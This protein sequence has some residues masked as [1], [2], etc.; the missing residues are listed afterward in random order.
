MTGDHDHEGP[1]Q[2]GW[3]GTC[4]AAGDTTAAGAGVVAGRFAGDQRGWRNGLGPGGSAFD[5]W[6]A[7]PVFVVRAA[8][9]LVREVAG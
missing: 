6:R 7:R 1:G 3:G 5:I 9:S 2:L 4:P 8:G